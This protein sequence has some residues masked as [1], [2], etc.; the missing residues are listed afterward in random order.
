MSRTPRAKW[1]DGRVVF[2]IIAPQVEEAIRSGRSVRSV[3]DE[4]RP[5]FPASYVQFARC[6]KK[7]L[8]H[9]V[10]PSGRGDRDGP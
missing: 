2:R 3:Y 9:E 6:V 4:M 5:R 7:S 10:R 1:G 8:A